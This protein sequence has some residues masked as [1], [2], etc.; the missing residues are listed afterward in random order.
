MLSVLLV[1]D[2]PIIK[3][4]FRKLIDWEACGF[5]IAGTASNGQEALRQIEAAPI[6][7]VITDLK[8]PQMDGIELIKTLK[9][10]GFDGVILVM[11]NYADFELVREA[12]V[13]GAMDYMLK[14]NIDAKS[15]QG[16]LEK[17][18]AELQRLR[19]DQRQHRLLTEQSHLLAERA[20]RE[21]LLA[22][23]CPP[24]PPAVD[25]GSADEPLWACEVALLPGEQRQV[26]HPPSSSR[27]EDVLRSIFEDVPGVAVVVLSEEEVL[28]VCYSRVLHA[29]GIRIEDKLE[30]ISRQMQ[31]YFNVPV[32]LITPPEAEGLAALHPSVQACRHAAEIRFYSLQ[33]QVL[34]PGSVLMDSLPDM[35]G[36]RE[37]ASRLAMLHHERRAREGLALCMDHMDR[38]RKALM[39]PEKTRAYWA[40]VSQAI[41][42]ISPG[43]EGSDTQAA[44]ETAC[45]ESRTEHQLMDAIRTLLPAL[46]DGTL[47][48]AFA[49]CRQEVRRALLYVHLHFAER[50]T[51]D[52]IAQDASLDRSYLCRLF[53]K[54][55]GINLFS[56]LNRLRMEAAAEQ[57]QN[58]NQYVKEV[59]ASVGVDDP[60]YFTR[61]F[62]NH[63]G[64]SPS[65]YRRESAEGEQEAPL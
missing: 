52:D 19:Q 54:E 38:C 9:A 10:Q 28:C 41:R 11:S 12:L 24:I 42:R 30:Q 40:Q 18:T 4:A 15:L 2:E 8:M 5:R 22:D 37:M 44:F 51:L 50:I 62:K 29:R 26:I 43:D 61:L 31:M 49:G 39:P 27:V 48:P 55:T 59:A 64:V 56:Y 45:G 46:L 17:A 21:Y 65:E 47:P 33:G 20:L 3:V 57:I 6:D 36:P 60:F 63:F 7:V 53:K 13:E 1:D 34:A 35:P 23:P 58:G 14:V 32:L 25:I 16:Q